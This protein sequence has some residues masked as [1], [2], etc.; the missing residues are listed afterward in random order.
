MIEAEAAFFDFEDNMKL[1]EEM[2]YFIVQ[3]VLERRRQDLELLGRDISKLEAIKLPFPRL[4][5]TEAV[6]LLK[7]KGEAFELGE[8]FGEPHETIISENFESAVFIQH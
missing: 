4:S 8:D 7:S 2:V 5:Y 3:R 6:E 1:Q